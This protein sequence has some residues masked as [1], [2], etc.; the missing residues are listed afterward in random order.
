MRAFRTKL[1]L[2]P[3]ILL[4]GGCAYSPTVDVLGSYF[5]AWMECIILGLA[6]ALIVRLL[7]I[8][9]GIYAH[10]RLKA[11]MF[12]CVAMVFALGVWLI[13]FRN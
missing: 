12:P 11:L 1:L 3:A 5:P 8:A 13:F 6:C 9:L 2:L 10:L 7:L 4:W